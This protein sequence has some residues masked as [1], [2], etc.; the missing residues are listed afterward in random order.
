VKCDT[1]SVQAWLMAAKLVYVDV[2]LKA[3]FRHKSQQ[4]E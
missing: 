2:Y 3:V 1:L 4:I